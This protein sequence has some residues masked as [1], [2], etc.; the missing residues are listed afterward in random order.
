M[1]IPPVKQSSKTPFDELITDW[2]ALTSVL[3]NLNRSMGLPDAYPFVLPAPTI[4]KIRF[5]H[6]VVCNAGTSS[7]SPNDSKIEAGQSQR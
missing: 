3:N 4:E 5:I 6:D 7:Q 2:Y 1:K